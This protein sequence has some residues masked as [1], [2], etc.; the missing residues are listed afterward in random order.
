MTDIFD[1]LRIIARDGGPLTA[2]DRALIARAADEIEGLGR[3]LVL[4]QVRLIESQQHRIALNDALLEAR[5]PRPVPVW[6]EPLTA[7]IT[8]SFMRTL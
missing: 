3:A 7:R 5:R 6:P 4:T 8:G 2:A 1:E